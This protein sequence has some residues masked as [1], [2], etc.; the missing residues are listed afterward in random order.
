MTPEP[1]RASAKTK[2]V[3][4]PSTAVTTT[5]L[6][7]V[8]GWKDL[9]IQ[10]DVFEFH[11][12]LQYKLIELMKGTT[13]EKA[14]DDLYPGIY[15]S[16]IKC[17]SVDYEAERRE[18]FNDLE[19]QSARIRTLRDSFKD[20]VSGFGLQE[21]K[22]G[23]NSFPAVLTIRLKAWQYDF[24]KATLVPVYD[25]YEYPPQIDLAEFLDPSADRSQ[26]WMYNLYAVVVHFKEGTDF[27]F[28]KSSHTEGWFKFHDDP[29]THVAEEGV[30]DAEP[31]IITFRSWNGES[32]DFQLASKV[33]HH[34]QLTDPSKLRF[35]TTYISYGGLKA[36]MNPGLKQTLE[37]IL[38]SDDTDDEVLGTP[39]SAIILYQEIATSA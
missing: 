23:I 11:Q 13:V 30:L 9:R 34:L 35:W 4:V 7:A 6:T 25:R 21:A 2:E 17:I 22:S 14:I 18:Q 15:T 37:R 8:F 36:V 39:G 19:L 33:C 38:S 20:F 5:E 27:A 10:R 29:V 26:S 16:R 1:Y 24:Q 12:E 32:P 3:M 28:I 31:A